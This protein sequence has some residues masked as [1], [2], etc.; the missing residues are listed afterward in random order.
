VDRLPRHLRRAGRDTVDGDGGP[1]DQP[2]VLTCGTALVTPAGTAAERE[3]T[4]TDADDTVV[5]FA[6]TSVTPAPAT[7]SIS[8]TAVTPADAVGGTARAT[9]TATADLAAGAYTVTLTATD[10]DGGSATC[11]LAFR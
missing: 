5:D 7:G 8:R 3:V 6:V 9:V 10:A 2:A 1:V 11:T 4:A